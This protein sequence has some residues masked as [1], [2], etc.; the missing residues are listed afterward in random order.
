M[1][2]N[3][4]QW[5]QP[6]PAH[7]I[8]KN[9]YEL[10]APLGCGG[11]GIT[12]R[13]L[14][15]ETG[16]NVAVKE[17][18]P[19]SLSKR[20]SLPGK[21][22]ICPDS[23]SQR[24]D[25]LRGK[26]RFLEEARILKRFYYLPCIVKILDCFE[27]NNTAYIIMEYL[28]GLTLAQYVAAN[29]P[30]TWQDLLPLIDPIL[31]ALMQ[32]HRQGLIHRDISPDNLI[33]STDHALH[34]IDFGA[35][36]HSQSE[37]NPTVILKAGFAPPEQY[38]VGGQLGTW[39]DVYALCA[40]IYF[41]LTAAPPTEAMK[42]LDMGGLSSV[43][44]V[45]G[46]SGDQMHVLR[47]G[48][49][50]RPSERYQNM[51]ELFLALHGREEAI[52]GRHCDDAKTVYGGVLDRRKRSRILR[53]TRGRRLRKII[54]PAACLL[55]G[56]A[57]LYLALYRRSGSEHGAATLA[58]LVTQPPSASLSAAAVTT[59]SLTAV[60]PLPD[61]SPS[62][63]LSMKNVVGMKQKKARRTIRQLDSS[64]QIQVEYIYSPNPSGQVIRQSIGAGTNFTEGSVTTILL[65]VSKGKKP[66]STASSSPSSP[67][68]A[69]SP[70]RDARPAIPRKTDDGFTARSDRDYTTIHI[71]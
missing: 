20:T 49:A 55:L 7:T 60:A 45:P 17:Y 36:D 3:D 25:Y 43:S 28:D 71:D 64:I 44:P 39:V 23:G 12:Y 14:C 35:A 21:S 11:F 30:F 8:L 63:V 51:E 34:L 10:L 18:F 67:A 26:E 53:S 62:A 33:F 56:L 1:L 5:Q 38:I 16:Q 52:D 27:E 32:I 65:T 54:Y 15:R 59:A 41:A 68:P 4:E 29:G 19:A 40:T 42:R 2:N 58:P 50:L 70:E 61:F 24:S 13:G 37:R 66:A 6:L 31:K 46:L 57:F 22:V 47:T 69:V 9:R 48:L